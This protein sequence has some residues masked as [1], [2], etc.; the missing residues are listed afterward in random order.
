MVDDAKAPAPVAELD[1]DKVSKLLKVVEKVAIVAPGFT[2]ISSEAMNQLRAIN[3]GLQK[4]IEA[5]Q[6]ARAKAEAE[7]EAKA[8]AEAQAA[9][10]EANKAHLEGILNPTMPPG[11]GPTGATGAARPPGPIPSSSVGAK[12]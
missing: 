3:E 10:L 5:E 1:A 7:A 12:P 8:Q 4:K 9:A 6:A 2:Y 11:M